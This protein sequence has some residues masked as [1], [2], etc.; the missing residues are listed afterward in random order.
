MQTVFHVR[1][2]GHPTAENQ[3]FGSKNQS[4]GPRLCITKENRQVPGK[5]MN[6]LSK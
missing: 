6:R 5:R 4:N 1:D 2:V 3:A